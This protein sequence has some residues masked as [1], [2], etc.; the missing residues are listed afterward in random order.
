MF[1]SFAHIPFKF[2]SVIAEER[3]YSIQMVNSFRPTVIV[4]SGIAISLKMNL[5][6]NVVIN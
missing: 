4:Q 6:E 5:F 3:K 1:V 2:S